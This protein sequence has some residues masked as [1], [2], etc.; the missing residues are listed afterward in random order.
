MPARGTDGFERADLLASYL[1]PIGA[2]IE[3][4][5]QAALS[6]MLGSEILSRLGKP[7]ERKRFLASLLVSILRAQEI[8]ARKRAESR[9]DGPK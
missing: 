2:W 3:K 5:E 6:T 4:G 7:D 8:A 9:L 1:D